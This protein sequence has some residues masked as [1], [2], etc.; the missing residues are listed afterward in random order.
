MEIINT[1]VGTPLGY[2]MRFCYQV[3]NIGLYDLICVYKFCV[4][5]A[6][7]KFFKINKAKQPN[8]KTTSNGITEE[9]IKYMVCS[10]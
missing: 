4:D 6:D 10:F 7:I 8:T 3:F 1:I 5:I 9:V 2:L